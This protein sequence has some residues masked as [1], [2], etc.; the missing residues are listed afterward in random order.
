M[1]TKLPHFDSKQSWEEYYLAFNF[2]R[3]M[4]A[5]EGILSAEVSVVNDED[6]DVTTALTDET[7]QSISG[8]Q[9][10]FYIR[11]GTSGVKYKI[12]CRATTTTEKY[13]LDADLTVLDL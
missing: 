5:E 3:V 2:F 1:A 6:E 7:K 9:V 4:R 10:I 12:T 8:T 13:E 11:G